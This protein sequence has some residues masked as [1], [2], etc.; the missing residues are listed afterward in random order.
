MQAVFDGWLLSFCPTHSARV[1]MLTATNYD[2]VKRK[3]GTIRLITR[4]IRCFK[5]YN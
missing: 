4:E 2:F 1:F 5:Q 3:N